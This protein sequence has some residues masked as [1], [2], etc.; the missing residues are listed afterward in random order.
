VNTVLIG[1]MMYVG[2]QLLVGLWVS[3]RIRSEEDYLLAGRSFGYGLATFSFFA[4]WFGAE[5][6][7]GAAGRIYQEGLSGAS[8]DPFGYGG[9]LLFM[10]L[11]FAAPLWRRG[12]TTLADLF[13]TRYSPAV[14]RLAVLMMAPTSVLWAAAQIRGF[15]QVLDASSSLGPVWGIS[16]AAV[17]AICYTGFGGMRADVITDLVQGVMIIIGL[18]LLLVAMFPSVESFQLAWAGI[19]P[20]RLRLFGSDRSWMRTLEAWAIPVCGS[21]VAQELV[22]RALACRSP[23]VARRS[24]LLGGGLYIVVGLVPAFLGLAAAASGLKLDDP[25]ELLP[26]LARTHLNVFC[27]I[28]FAGALVSAILSTVDSTLLAASSLVTHNLIAP[29]RPAMDEPAKLRLSRAGVIAAGLLAW[30]LALQAD[31]IFELV[32]G[33]SAFGSAGIFVI[34]VL[35]LFSRWGGPPS[36]LAA[37]IA[38]LAVWGIGKVWAWPCVYLTSLAAAFTAY[39]IVGGWRSALT[40]KRGTHP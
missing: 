22:A 2:L 38:G 39:L 19:D 35:G 40:S 37:L 24:A 7:I 32:E 4:T 6:C 26:Q 18:G 5:T 14:E 21:V 34:V 29:L 12:L 9:C 13:R 3:R 30:V 36:A 31:T 1:V 25:E 17:V 23:Q 20:Q 10:G 11:V 16:S 28:L 33:A 8:A 27:Q 15:G